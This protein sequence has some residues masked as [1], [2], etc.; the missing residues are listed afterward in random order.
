M[1]V[2]NVDSGSVSVFLNRSDIPTAGV[3]AVIEYKGPLSVI[4]EAY[5]FSQNYQNP[6]IPSDGDLS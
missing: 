6:C 4:P 2:A 1:A 3:T 5:A